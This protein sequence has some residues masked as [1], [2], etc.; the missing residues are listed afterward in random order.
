MLSRLAVGVRVDGDDETL[1]GARTERRPGGDT[2]QGASLRALG[3]Q[4][5]SEE[6]VY[7]EGGLGERKQE[8]GVGRRCV[9]LA[10]M[11]SASERARP[12]AQ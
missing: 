9:T 8:I 10:K 5:E 7:R 6:N 11:T 12:A 2:P 4:I 1:E 3:V